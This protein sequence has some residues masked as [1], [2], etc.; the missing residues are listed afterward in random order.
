MRTHELRFSCEWRCLRWKL[1]SNERKPVTVSSKLRAGLHIE[2]CHAS[3]QL[4]EVQTLIFCLR[5]REVRQTWSGASRSDNCRKA[6]FGED[7]EQMYICAQC[8]LDEKVSLTDQMASLLRKY[9]H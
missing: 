1:V 7:K 6:P 9:C 5:I 3:E 2:H 4:I 8:H